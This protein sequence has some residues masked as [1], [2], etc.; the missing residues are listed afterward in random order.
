MTTT[1]SSAGGDLYEALPAIPAGAGTIADP[2][3]RVLQEAIIAGT[4]PQGLHLKPDALSRRYGVSLIP[5][6]ECLRTLQAEGWVITE[7]HR[8]TYVRRGTEHELSDL[9]E[10]RII[11]EVAA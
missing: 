5:V 6:R 4:L 7:P 11:L 1:F 2:L 3:Q 9:F 8:G 10:V